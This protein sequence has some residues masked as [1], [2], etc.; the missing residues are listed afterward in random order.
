EEVFERRAIETS[1]TPEEVELECRADGCAV[2]LHDAFST[3]ERRGR[4]HSLARVTARDVR[5]RQQLRALN[6]VEP[7]GPLHVQRGDPEIAVVL[8]RELDEPLELGREHEL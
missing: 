8:E 1:Q 6:A 7:A 4:R 2:L 5:V 3:G